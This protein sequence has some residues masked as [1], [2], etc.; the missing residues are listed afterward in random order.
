MKMKILLV[1]LMAAIFLPHAKAQNEFE[2]KEGDTT[3]IMKKYYMCFLKK[4]DVRGQDS[5]TTAEIQKR[6]ME[7]ME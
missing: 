3:Y 7:N 6:H 5:A 4:G 2:M 1:L